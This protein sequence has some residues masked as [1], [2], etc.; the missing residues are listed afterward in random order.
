MRGHT[1]IGE[2]SIQMNSSV[3]PEVGRSTPAAKLFI[4]P[5]LSQLNPDFT[6]DLSQLT[7][8]F[9]PDLSQLNPDFPPDLSQLNPDFPQGGP[10]NTGQAVRHDCISRG[11]R[12]PGECGDPGRKRS[13]RRYKLGLTLTRNCHNLT[14]ISTPGINSI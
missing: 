2:A 8:D 6:S 7:P 9:T 1:A 5:N 11:S 10:I 4:T 14:R 13:L 3:N 12:R